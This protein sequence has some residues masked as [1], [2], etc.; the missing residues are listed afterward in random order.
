MKALINIKVDSE[1]KIASQNIA[2]S[3][4]VPLSVIINA[5]L[6]EFIR[7]RTFS[8]SMDPEPND[9]VV[10]DI[11]ERSAQ[12]KQNPKK[13]AVRFSNMVDFRAQYKL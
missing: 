7:T 4:G 3:L 11:L 2:D 1:V 8:V 10:A 13:H 6:R 9:T 5:H 12:Y